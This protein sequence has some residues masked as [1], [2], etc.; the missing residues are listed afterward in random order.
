MTYIPA[1]AEGHSV[2]SP[3][4]SHMWLACPGSLLPNLAAPDTSGVDAAIGTVAHSVA[5]ACLR[6]GDVA[7]PGFGYA[8][9][10]AEGLAIE[11]D[12]EMIDAVGSYVEWCNS[13]ADG[14]SYVAMEQKVDFSRWTPLTDQTGTADHV[15]IWGTKFGG[16]VIFTDLKYGKGV[17]IFAENNPQ[18][19]MYALGIYDEWDWAYDIKK[20]TLRIC[21]PRLGHFDSWEITTKELLKFG[22]YVRE[23]ATL[24]LQPDAPR[25]AG[26]KQCRFCK[27]KATEVNGRS[28]IC[29]AVI[30]AIGQIADDTF[31]VLEPLTPARSLKVV[32][33]LD[34]GRPVPRLPPVAE[35]TTAHLARILP[36]RKMVEGWFKAAYTEAERRALDGQTVEGWKIVDGRS[37]RAWKDENA[38]AGALIAAGV[39]AYHEKIVS[40]A[41]AEK[42][43]N[44]VRAD[45]VTK[46]DVT[47][48]L[49]RLTDKPAGR[50]TLVPLKDE[51][52]DADDDAG[53]VFGDES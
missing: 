33:S 46:K 19:M 17:K 2:F 52:P 5:E 4:S 22:E 8:G 45:G 7:H 26:E 38:A 32:E 39:R 50:P 44:A 1:A 49:S 41:E 25:L 14:A 36:Y 35:L 28:V 21:Q 16:D 47:N 43:L 27:V 48:W 6:T 34:D 10:K 37:R 23:R 51:R 12:Q 15:A 29:P 3:S 13:V 20:F 42:E 24:A 53:D 31:E 11:V 40:P 18:L 9:Q 30:D